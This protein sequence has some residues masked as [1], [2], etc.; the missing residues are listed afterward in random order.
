MF[1][2]KK[3]DIIILRLVINYLLFPFLISKFENDFSSYFDA[4]REDNAEK[5]FNLSDKYFNE[6]VSK[7]QSINEVLHI[8]DEIITAVCG[9]P[10]DAF[11]IDERIRRIFN[12]INGL[13]HLRQLRRKW[14][15]T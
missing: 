11:V 7:Q 10:A 3:K 1:Q 4:N 8:Y 2:K 6:F 15:L 5:I 13:S 9:N 12:E 14:I